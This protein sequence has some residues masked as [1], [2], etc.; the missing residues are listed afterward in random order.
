ME[1]P[2]Y[3]V[4]FLRVLEDVGTRYGDLLRPGETALAQC[5]G[6]LPAPAKRLFVR[7]LT[8]RGPWIRRDALAYPEVE[9]LPGALERLS[10]EGFCEDAGQAPHREAAAL[11]RKGEIEALLSAHGVPFRKAEPRGALEARLLESVPGRAVLD[12]APAVG[13]AGPALAWARLLF[14][15]FFGN[16]EQDLADFVVADLGHVRYETYEADPACRIF[17]SREEVDLLVSLGDLREAF[18]AGEDLPGVTRTL[19]DLER[20][21]GIRPQRRYHRLLCDVGR[22]WERAGDAAAALACYGRSALPPARERTARILLAAGDVPGAAAAALAMAEAPRDPGEARFARRCLERLAR[23]D[24]S[25]AAWAASHP[26]DP[27]PPSLRLRVPRH[28]SGSVEQ[29]A[30]AAAEGWR[31]WHTENAL[32]TA[33]YGLAF[34]D[35]LFAPVPGAFQH[36][37]QAAPADLRLPG[38]FEARREAIRARL[39]DLEEPGAP[40]RLILAMEEQKRGVANVFVNWRAVP[41][42]LLEAALDHVPPA[43]LLEVLRTLAP[44][45]AAWRSGFPDLFLCAPG[46]AALWEVKGPGDAL[47]PEQERWLGIFNRAGLESL[48]VR[49]EYLDDPG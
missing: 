5:F 19:L 8:R 43:A 28:P 2:Y 23:R 18:E 44:N 41:R 29:A 4:N 12:A 34:W 27:P 33:L 30:L 20:F 15:L 9:D 3:L 32:W 45:P 37:F 31:G 24:P 26:P 42:D 7:L 14:L 46:R 6:A 16:A 49:V 1:E 35:V 11:L 40:R 47:R 21:A 38:F 10:A 48:V 22:A 39:R 17:G 36:R 13:V 25:A